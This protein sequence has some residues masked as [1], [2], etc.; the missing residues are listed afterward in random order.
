MHGKINGE[1]YVCF[2]EAFIMNIGDIGSKVFHKLF[3]RENQRQPAP[4]LEAGDSPAQP[5]D[6]ALISTKVIKDGYAQ[7]KGVIDSSSETREVPSEKHKGGE[8]TVK[9][10]VSLKSGVTI[11][12]D[13]KTHT[14]T[15]AKN[16]G[17]GN[18]Q[19][20]AVFDD[21]TLT[22]PSQSAFQSPL[23]IENAALKETITSDGRI[24][25]EDKKHGVW[26]EQWRGAG[27]WDEWKSDRYVV[28]PD[29]K[30]SGA[31]YDFKIPYQ[32]KDFLVSL[33]DPF[34]MNFVDGKELPDGSI[35]AER[36]PENVAFKPFVT[37]S[38]VIS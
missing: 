34:N 9:K 12:E 6:A 36:G 27:H 33:S 15:I 32:K 3:G 16:D 10:E 22:L 4:P 24:E 28:T 21:A 17:S 38:Y 13:T 8:K 23:T 19:T 35:T 31:Q 25:F 20:L 30:V 18:P 29:G 37:R 2:E 11:T 26:E 14:V 5:T 1:K 7:N